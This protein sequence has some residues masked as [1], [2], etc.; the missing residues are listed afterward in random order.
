MDAVILRTKDGGRDWQS[1]PHPFVNSGLHIYGVAC[2][3]AADCYVTG[4]G[5]PKVDCQSS[6]RLSVVLGTTDGGDSWHTLLHTS[7]QEQGVPFDL[8]LEAITCSTAAH[9]IVVGSPG[10]ILVTEDGGRIWKRASSRASGTNADMRGVT[11]ATEQTCWAVGWGCDGAAGCYITGFISTILAT[12]D[13][14]RSWRQ[15]RSRHTIRIEGWLC[16]S[17][18]CWSGP[19][20]DAVACVSA[21]ECRAVG[22]D[23][24]VLV[25]RDSG[26]TWTSEPT[27]TSNFLGG[28]SCPAQGACFTVGIGGT[29]LG[30]E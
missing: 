30:L 2:A 17:G 29:I 11:C 18:V 5:C 24:T 25:T 1:L 28:I 21:S 13:G 7:A 3:N 12:R 27:P 6:E 14:G 15:Q 16:G 19:A 8:I 23:G 20:L 26:A 10:I 22:E 9:C 4:S